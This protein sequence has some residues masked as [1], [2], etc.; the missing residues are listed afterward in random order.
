[1]N[2]MTDDDCFAVFRHDG[3]TRNA[4]RGRSHRGPALGRPALPGRVFYWGLN[5]T[6]THIRTG[7]GGP[8]RWADWIAGRAY[9]YIAWGRESRSG[10]IVVQFL[11]S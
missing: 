6:M 5:H 1:M 11:V 7:R 10:G 2:K 4:G 3:H 8:V 9:W